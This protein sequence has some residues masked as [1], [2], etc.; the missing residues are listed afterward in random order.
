MTIRVKH[1]A[2]NPIIRPD[3]ENSPGSNINGPSL[4]RVPEWVEQPLG[5]YYLYFADHKGKHIRLAYASRLIGPWTIHGPG[6][7]QLGESHFLTGQ[8][9]VPD[10]MPSHLRTLATVPRERLQEP[11]A[12][13]VPSVW[14]DLTHPHIASPD[15]HVD[16]KQKV[17]RMYYHGL[18]R[19][20]YQVSRMAT[21]QDGIGFV[22]RE[23]VIVDKSY[24][25]AFHHN[26][27]VYA[28][29]MPGIFY[30]SKDGVTGFEKGPRLFD[31]NMRHAALLVTDEH[32][33]VFWTQVGDAP[34]RILLSTIDIGDDWTTWKE[35]QPVEVLRPTHNWEGADLPIAP[36]VRSSVNTPVNQLRDPCI[37]QE[38][39]RTFLLY[40]VAGESGI[41][42][43]ELLID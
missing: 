15:V 13:H 18:D 39:G 20:G 2:D 14:D 1:M 12:P 35:S 30:R 31:R 25:K 43:V 28:M 16:H 33:L 27:M 10:P 4:I 32:L 36:S 37:F 19:F 40:V 38:D 3:M 7:L 34:E 22:A 24:L 41:A 5:K 11:R 29:A 21:S 6:S 23:E 42:I 26:G 9:D 17:I 8:P